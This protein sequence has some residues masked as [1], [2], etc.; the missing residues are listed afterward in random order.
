MDYFVIRA[1]KKHSAGNALFKVKEREIV[2]ST[3]GD[4]YTQACPMAQQ[5]IDFSLSLEMTIVNLIPCPP[6]FCF[7]SGTVMF[8]LVFGAGAKVIAKA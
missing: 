3:E 2:I 5:C 1:L 6:R 8:S 7:R 4:V